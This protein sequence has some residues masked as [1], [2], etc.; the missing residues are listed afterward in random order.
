[1]KRPVLLWLRRDF[2]LADHPALTAAVETGSP[3]IPVVINDEVMSSLGAA[4]GWRM[5]EAIAHFDTRLS[6]LGSKLV[7]RSGNAVEVLRQLAAETGAQSVYWSRWY[8]PSGVARDKSVKAAL[9]A[10]GIDAR[11]FPGFLV[12][13]PWTVETGQ[14]RPYSVYS[15][16]WRAVRDRPVAEPLPAPDILKAPDAWPDS[17]KISEWSLGAGMSRGAAVVARHA[18]IGEMVAMS[19]LDRFCAERLG[20][21]KEDRNRPDLEATSRLSENLT[22][23]EI[24]PRTVW[25][26][27]QR[28]LQSGAAGAEHFLKELVWREFAWHLLWYAPNLATKNWREKWDAFP[29]QGA[30]EKSQAWCFGETGIEMVDAGMRE[31]YVTGTMHNRVR[32]IAASYLTKH[33]GTD[34][35]IGRAWFEETL[36]D[37]DPAANAM[38]WQWVAGCGPDAAPYFRIFNPDTQAQ[39]YDPERKYRGNFLDQDGEGAR[40]FMA[41]IPESRAISRPAKPIASLPE[42]RARALAAYASVKG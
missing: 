17:E 5:A 8:E 32:M 11:S 41:A 40:E 10:D 20:A 33:L 14:G 30:S 1:M 7:L 31:L 12:F 16:F 27:G 35:R 26:R 6:V 22:Y 9:V 38:G 37:W 13:E 18:G 23:G 25:H 4:A 24:S 19:R 34:W 39:T 28:A 42:G 36:I 3:I 29:W 2:R 21:Y 15:P